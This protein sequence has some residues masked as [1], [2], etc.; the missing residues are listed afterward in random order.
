[1]PPSSRPPTSEAFCQDERRCFAAIFRGTEKP[2]LM[3]KESQTNQ[4]I[5]VDIPV[6]YKVLYIQKVVV[7]D[8]FHQPYV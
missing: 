4:L 1:M 8:F 2:L 3:V 7:W 5:M 6:F